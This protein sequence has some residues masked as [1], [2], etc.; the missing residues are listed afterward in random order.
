MKTREIVLPVIVA[1]PLSAVLACGAAAA[2]ETTVRIDGVPAVRQKPDFCGEACAAM[3][4]QKLGKAADQDWVFDQSGL[5]PVEGRGC[6]TRELAEALRRIGFDC[7]KVWESARA[8]AAETEMEKR[9]RTLYEDL[10]K[11]VPSIVCMRYD[12]APGASEHFRLVVGY[13]AA[14]QELLYHEP[15]ED[16]GA[17]R[18]MAKAR[19]LD[20]WPLKYDAEDWTVIRLRLEPRKLIEPAP[21]A[22]FSAADYAQHVLALKKKLPAGFT[23]VVEPPFVVLG[24]E[25]PAVVRERSEKTVRWAVEKLKKAY[26]AKNPSAILDVWLFKDEKSYRKHALE[27]FGDRPSTPFGYYSKEHGALVMNI[28]SGGGTLVHEIVHPFI[29]SN[30]PGC[31][32]WFNEGLASLYEQCGARNDAIVGYTNWRLEGLQKAIRGRSLPPFK[33]LMESDSA[34]FYSMDRGTNYAQARYLCYYLQ[35]KGLLIRYFKDFAARRHVD[36]S[37]HETLKKV[38]GREDIE[39]FQE[40]W[41]AFVLG[42]RFP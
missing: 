41:E 17:Y 3:A 30:F 19:F 32:S 23:I 8:S 12:D 6:R 16:D 24:D 18:R 22:G 33:E 14:A 28:R 7:G 39:R 10:K 40:E 37:G 1:M 5:D 38:L 31:P 27:L 20:L 34:G 29:E 13:D 25:A 4:L 15:A 35:E 42:L 2:N 36:S 26:F 21:S 11:G 9:W